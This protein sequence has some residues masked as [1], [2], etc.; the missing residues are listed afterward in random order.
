MDQD[1]PLRWTHEGGPPVELPRAF[2]L[3][4]VEEVLG[5]VVDDKPDGLSG[6]QGVEG[7]EDSFV[8][9]ARIAPAGADSAYH[10][11]GVGGPSVAP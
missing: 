8:P 6:C 9:D 7:S 4:H 3:E 5:V 2:G 10:V 1:P 11:V